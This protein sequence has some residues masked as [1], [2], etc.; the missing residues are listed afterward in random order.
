MAYWHTIIAWGRR[1]LKWPLGKRL[2]FNIIW[3]AQSSVAW[4]TW[5]SQQRFYFSFVLIS[6]TRNNWQDRKQIVFFVAMFPSTVQTATR[7]FNESQNNF[8]FNRLMK[9]ESLTTFLAVLFIKACEIWGKFVF[10]KPSLDLNTIYFTNYVNVYK[11]L[12]VN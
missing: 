1:L 12:C 11:M 2:K 6:F 5:G 9:E 7:L 8:I 10:C 4:K 3:S